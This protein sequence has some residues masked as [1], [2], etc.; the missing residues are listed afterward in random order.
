VSQTLHLC[1]IPGINSFRESVN[2]F[3]IMVSEVSAHN[4]QL[5]CFWVHTQAELH[6][7]GACA[8]ATHLWVNR[9]QHEPDIKFKVMPVMICL[10]RKWAV[11]P[12]T[13]ITSQKI[14]PLAEC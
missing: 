12:E 1:G 11:P 4:H 2:L 14:A 10:P 5:H 9:K 13:S 7:A 6:V 3:Y 8:Q